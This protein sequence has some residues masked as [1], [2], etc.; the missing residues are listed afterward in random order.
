MKF[1]PN[2][3]PFC[4]KLETWLRMADIQYEVGISKKKSKLNK[5]HNLLNILNIT[6]KL[7]QKNFFQ[8]LLFF[9]VR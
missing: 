3:S 2:I 1:I 6:I 5:C 7:S 4:L 9:L 8:L